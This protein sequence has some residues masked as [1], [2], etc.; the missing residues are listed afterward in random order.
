K[1][2]ILIH[3]KP[4]P[5]GFVTINTDGSVLP[6]N[7]NA[8]AGGIIRDWTGRPLAVFAANLG[9][10]TITR[11]ELRAADIGLRIAWDLG[12]RKAHLQLDSRVA[13]EAIS[14]QQA[15]DNRHSQTIKSIQDMLNRDWEVSSYHIYREGNMVA[16]RFALLGH[17]LNFG[18]SINC[19]YPPDI[20]KIIW[21]D[22]VGACFSRLIIPNE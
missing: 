16:D 19:L 1:E 20:D 5:E 14:N 11:A 2:Q 7:G 17:S 13:V 9:A 22:Y 18:V 8:T 12:Y 6:Q 21:N 15:G 10:C 3:W 4:A